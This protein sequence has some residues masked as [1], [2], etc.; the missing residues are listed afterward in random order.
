VNGHRLPAF[1][2]LVAASWAVC[3]AQR[4]SV[5]SS[6][7]AGVRLDVSVF[8]GPAV[9]HGLG[10]QQFEVLDNN[11]RQQF[12]IAETSDAPLDL[13][14]VVQPLQSL[15]VD[16]Q[17]L[18]VQSS[19]ALGR[20]LRNGDRAGVVIAS[21]PPSVVRALLPAGQQQLPEVPSGGESV[22]LRDAIMQT[23]AQFD[24]QNR[25]KALVCFTDG[26]HDQS[27]VTETA[28][29][30]AADRQPAEVIVAGIDITSSKAGY[31]IWND[32]RRTGEDLA[33]Y[34]GASELDVPRWL[35]EVVRRSGGRTVNLRGSKA[36]EQLTNLVADLRSQYVITY[37]PAG[38]APQGWHDIKVVLKGRKGTVSTRAG[39]W[40]SDIG[41]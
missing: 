3:A 30:T 22:A 14:L 7:T 6:L 17:S 18:I 28:V 33:R 25:R 23:L 10:P 21:A 40:G 29:R 31:T 12:S 19:Q 32:G 20:T 16:R 36:A 35:L 27:W 24:A 9:V 2:C 11:V 5:F 37:A 8:D 41:G 1:A 26:Q 38:V 4:P 15:T 39:Y 34:A 13:L